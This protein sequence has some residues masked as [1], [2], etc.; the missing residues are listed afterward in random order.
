[1]EWSGVLALLRLWALRDKNT[2]MYACSF[3]FIFNIYIV[4]LVYACF[5]EIP[6][7]SADTNIIFIN[8]IL[9]LLYTSLNFLCMLALRYS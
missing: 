1:M 3:H 8:S 6:F 7:F 9:V 4:E 2:L 5:D